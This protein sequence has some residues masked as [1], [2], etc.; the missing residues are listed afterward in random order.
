MEMKEH[1]IARQ[2]FQTQLRNMKD[3]VFRPGQFID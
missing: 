1:L 2:D 3:A